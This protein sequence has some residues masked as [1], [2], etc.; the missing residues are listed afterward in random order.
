MTKALISYEEWNFDSINKRQ[1]EFADLAVNI[2]S[3]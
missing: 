1:R 2:W 3:L